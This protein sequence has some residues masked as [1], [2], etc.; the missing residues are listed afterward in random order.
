VVRGGGG[1]V[2]IGGG[3]AMGGG[4]GGGGG[5]G[6]GG[7]IG[8]GLGGLILLGLLAFFLGGRG[9]AGADAAIDTIVNQGGGLVG[10]GQ[11]AMPQDEGFVGDCTAE[12]ANRDPNCQLSATAQSLDAFWS[13]ALRT[14]ANVRY[15]EPDVV[16][17]SGQTNTPCGTANAASGPFYCPA[18][19]TIYVDTAFYQ[20]LVQQFGGSDGPLAREYI[21]AHEFGHHIQHQLGEFQG[22]RSGT[23][24]DSMSVRIELQADCFAGM[25]AR[26]AS[27]MPDPDTGVPFLQRL[28]EQDIHDALAAAAAVGDDHIQE[29]ATGTANPESFTHGTSEQRMHWFRIGYQ[30]GTLAACDTLRAADLG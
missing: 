29:I 18:D 15:T 8:G 6:R 13:N 16:S 27:T 24:A 25:W 23:G 14:Q 2:I 21:L 1:P 22:D 4:L 17:F 30:N 12:Q 11:Q 7:M 19:A 9:G 10:Q 26:T 3:P 28:T 5:F 20:D